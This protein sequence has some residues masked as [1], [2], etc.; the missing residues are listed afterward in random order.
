[1]KPERGAARTECNTVV[2]DLDS[3]CHPF[4][5]MIGHLTGQFC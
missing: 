4:A 2:I 3:I 1:V 5:M